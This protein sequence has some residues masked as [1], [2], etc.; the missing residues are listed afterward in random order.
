M[1]LTLITI[2]IDINHILSSFIITNVTR[3]IRK[4]SHPHYRREAV[5]DSQTGNRPTLLNDKY[6][7]KYELR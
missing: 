5:L 7:Y 4:G 1:R 3:A 2:H 6:E